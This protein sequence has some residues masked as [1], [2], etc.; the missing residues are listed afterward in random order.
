L[1]RLPPRGDRN[2]AAAAFQPAKDAAKEGCE[3]LGLKQMQNV[4]IP[5]E[6]LTVTLQGIAPLLMRSGRLA[7]PLDE[8]VLELG[9]ITKMRMKTKADH[10]RIA[11]IEWEGSLWLSAG[12]PCIPGEAL[13][14]CIAKA[15][16]LKKAKASVRSGLFVH[17]NPPLTYEGPDDLDSLRADS[18]Y[19]LRVAVAVQ[20]KKTMRTRPRFRQ[21]GCKFTIEYNPSLLSRRDVIEY[22]T[23]AGVQIGLGDWRP[24]Y[25]RF[26]VLV[27]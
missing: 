14:A 12:R 26:N 6:R 9:A 18:A 27:E 25:G 13:E 20:N 5:P 1:Y 10:E 24:R 16:S 3:M 22:L 8:Y 19:R 2:V 23:V 4:A 21:W 7:D 11:D 17:E 15:A